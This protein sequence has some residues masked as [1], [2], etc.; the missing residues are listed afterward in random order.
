MQLPILSVKPVIKYYVIVFKESAGYPEYGSGINSL[1]SVDNHRI[2]IDIKQALKEQHNLN[3][4]NSPSVHINLRNVLHNYRGYIMRR[5]IYD[6]SIY[7]ITGDYTYSELV[8]N[9]ITVEDAEKFFNSLP[10]E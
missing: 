4:A 8:H 10:T 5:G 7:G 3:I 6:V 2:S 9:F 1:N